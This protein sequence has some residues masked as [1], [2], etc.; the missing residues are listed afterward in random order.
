MVD[1]F[2]ALGMRRNCKLNIKAS[3]YL[4]METIVKELSEML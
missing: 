4:N 3:K 1:L 2:E